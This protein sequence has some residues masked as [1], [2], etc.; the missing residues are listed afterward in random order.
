M[1]PSESSMV[2]RALA[3]T[4]RY[5]WEI[6]K[7]ARS[8]IFSGVERRERI[9][10]GSADAIGGIFRFRGR[11]A[12]RR[13]LHPVWNC[14]LAGGPSNLLAMKRLLPWVAIIACASTGMG[15]DAGRGAGNFSQPQPPL[16]FTQICSL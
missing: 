14:P 12:N 5:P 16:L 1:V 15:A 7:G 8:G 9:V 10:R 4:S 13:A 2:T 11:I 6:P 3:A